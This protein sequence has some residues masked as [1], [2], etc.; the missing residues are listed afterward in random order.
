MQPAQS[1]MRQTRIL[2]VDDEKTI[3]RAWE[4]I[5][6]RQEWNVETC[7]NGLEAL[8]RFR[9]EPFD[10]VMLDIMM[11]QISGMDVLRELKSHSP[12]TE[13]IMM[14]AYATIDTAVAAIKMGAYEYLTKPFENID[15]VANLVHRAVERKRLVDYNR[16]L[17]SEL[18]VRNRFEGMV[19]GSPKMLEV[20]KL[21]ESV[22]YST[23]S[24][25]IQ[26][27][28]GTGKE[29]VAKAIHFRSPRKD[30]A[31]VVVNCS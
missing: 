25:L 23:A 24:V 3:L 21:V 18:E 15:A 5:R 10:V 26:G 28:S 20:F 27:E 16:R 1:Q 9:E 11:P 29:L 13:V 17:E 19:G 14:T 7:D 31:F 2:I 22:A 4:R 6:A 30:R 8:D 12:D